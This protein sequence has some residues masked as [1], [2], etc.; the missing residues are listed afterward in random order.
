[1]R[2][3]AAVTLHKMQ[4]GHLRD[5]LCTSP[6]SVIL[7]SVFSTAE[8]FDHKWVGLTSTSSGKLR[9][10]CCARLSSGASDALGLLA[11]CMCE[12][13]DPDVAST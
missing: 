4:S 8:E 1:M 10:N 2:S 7:S 13:A 9:C 11:G 3:C 5:A 12:H 6:C